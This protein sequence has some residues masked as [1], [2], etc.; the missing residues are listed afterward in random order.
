MVASKVSKTQLSLNNE[1][2]SFEYSEENNRETDIKVT[3]Y[4]SPI[5]LS[6]NQK[7]P[8]LYGLNVK[9]K[10]NYKSFISKLGPFQAS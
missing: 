1:I 3:K 8:C 4:P 5:K 2:Y 10:S 7:D 9:S 6:P